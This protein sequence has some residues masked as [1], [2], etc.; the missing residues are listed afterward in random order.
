MMLSG[1][2]FLFSNYTWPSAHFKMRVLIGDITHQ[3]AALS[4]Q[5]GS[6]YTDIEDHSI[7]VGKKIDESHFE[8]VIISDLKQGAG[9]KWRSIYANSAEIS[10]SKKAGI[11][12]ITLYDG[13][14]D[15]EL[16]PGSMKGL[17]NPFRHTDFD[18]LKLNMNVSG[19]DLDRT[20]MD[21]YKESIVYKGYKELTEDVDSIFVLR[22]TQVDRVGNIL[23]NKFLLFRDT[24]IRIDKSVAGLKTLEEYG[25]PDQEKIFKLINNHLNQS[26][27][28]IGNRIDTDITF[29]DELLTHI[30][31]ARNR[32]FTLSIVIIIL[33]FIGAPLGAISK[34]GG[35]GLP[36]VFAVVM[37]IVYYMLS[38][39]GEKMAKEQILSPFWG[40][41]LSSIILSPIALF[42]LLKANSESKI[43]DLSFYKKLLKSKN[44]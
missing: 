34:K 21:G 29:Y 32:I 43:F 4:F 28:D 31:I 37:F 14:W 27:I 42:L 11:L 5:E 9:Y 22:N 13:F 44:N 26:K 30:N 6:Y 3:K 36:V 15:E 10:Q 18:K 17:E 19:F 1:A 33:F 7:Y 39:S 12:Q 40:M 23:L 41:W 25:R 24:S 20:D 8:Q 38:I 2:A 16:H 35:I